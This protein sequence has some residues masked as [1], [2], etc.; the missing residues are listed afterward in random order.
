MEYLSGL[1][2]INRVNNFG[3]LLCVILYIFLLAVLCYLVVISVVGKA[4]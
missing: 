2:K 1:K 3:V 4:C